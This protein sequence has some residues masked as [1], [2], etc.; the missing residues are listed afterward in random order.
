MLMNEVLQRSRKLESTEKLELDDQ[1]APAQLSGGPD[2]G[3]PAPDAV[4]P[5]VVETKDDDVADQGI[6]AD[7]IVKDPPEADY[8][9]DDDDDEDDGN[10]AGTAASGSTTLPPD[11]PNI[12]LSTN[13]KTEQ[14]I[15]TKC[16]KPNDPQNVSCF[17]CQTPLERPDVL[18]SVSALKVEKSVRQHL[19]Y[20][21][22]PVDTI[23]T[24]E[25]GARI[26]FA[27]EKADTARNKAFTREFKHH[28]RKHR[29]FTMKK[30]HLPEDNST[31]R[32][33]FFKLREEGNYENMRE[34]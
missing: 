5:E 4:A 1:E 31:R 12:T 27:T 6:D 33:Y 21:R 10:E 22:V 25:L 30:A 24:I 29:K 32:L 15:C 13:T 2:Q 34:V 11:D 7:S 14:I 9:L 18:P 8:G 19:P 28:Q 17:S 23:Y 20:V 26:A 3:N 16:H